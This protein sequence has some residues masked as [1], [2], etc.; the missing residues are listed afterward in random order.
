MLPGKYAFTFYTGDEYI[1][2]IQSGTTDVLADG[3][4]VGTASPAELRVTLRRGGG[5][6]HGVVTGLRPG[7]AGTVVL[8]RAAGLSGIPTVTQAFLDPN[9]GEAQF[10][11]GNLAPGEYQLYAWPATQE[12]EYRNPEA[13]RA[14]SGNAVAVSLHEHGE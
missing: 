11:A 8:I 12:V 14:L 2:S 6:I 4:E 7:E 10:F 9:V 3:L 13:M 5:S 1:Q